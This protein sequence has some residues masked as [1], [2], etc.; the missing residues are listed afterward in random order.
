MKKINLLLPLILLLVIVASCSKEKRIGRHLHSRDGKWTIVKYNVQQYE[1][2][3]PLES[4]GVSDAGNIVFEKNGSFV[5]T[6]TISSTT[7][8]KTGTW[9]NTESDISMNYNG[10]TTVFRIIDESRKE[11]QIRHTAEYTDPDGYYYETRTTLEL[12]KK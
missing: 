8:I 9:S 3:W 6:Q 12:E 7:T 1:N 4:E 11:L 2:G 5:W 10:Q